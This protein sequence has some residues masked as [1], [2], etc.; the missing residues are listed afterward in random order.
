[1]TAHSQQPNY[2]HLG[3]IVS[4]YT[5]KTSAYLKY[6]NI[7]HTDRAPN[8]FELMH[9]TPKRVGKAIMPTLQTPEGDWLQDSTEIIDALE[10][11]HPEHSI[12]PQGAKQNIAAHLFEL[13]G[14]EW[15]VLS[16]LHYRWSRPDSAEFIVNEFAR[17]GVPFLPR[18]MGRLVGRTIRDKMKA[19]LPRFGIEGQTKQGLEQFTQTLLTQLDT[20]FEQHHYLLGGRPCVGDF[21][22]Y[23]QIYAHLYRDPGSKPLFDN[24]PHLIAWIERMGAPSSETNSATNNEAKGDFLA[25]DEIPATLTPILKTI[26]S[27]QF[28]FSNKVINSIQDYANNQPDAKRV[29][30][31]TGQTDYTIGG[32]NGKRSMFSFVQWKVQR[33]WD[34]L[35]HLKGSE[36]DDAKAWLKTLGGDALIDMKIEHRVKREGNSE[37]LDR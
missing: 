9:S 16:S 35:H 36:A 4:P 12:I 19:Y 13:H 29:S 26:F 22:M 32:V 15:L 18:F 30:R 25:N 21:A 14:D 23:G 8:V 33:V 37:V 7:P 20:H 34:A 6:K 27:E 3:W 10:Q 11:R 28:E 2:Q 24:T 17:L 1:M 5:Q 31:I